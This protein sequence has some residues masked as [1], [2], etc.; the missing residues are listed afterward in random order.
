MTTAELLLPALQLV[1]CARRRP[2][3]TVKHASLLAL[4]FLT[5]CSLD[6][7]TLH[8]QY[9][10][11]MHAVHAA[12]EESLAAAAGAQRQAAAAATAPADR[13]RHERL[14]AALDLFGSEVGL[15]RSAALLQDL[16]RLS[17]AGSD[18]D[19]QQQQQASGGSQA[20]AAA[21]QH[22]AAYAAY[23]ASLARLCAAADGLEEEEQVRCL[24]ACKGGGGLACKGGS[25]QAGRQAAGCTHARR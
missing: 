17:A 16:Q 21:S 10:S 25:R 1:A 4:A 22:A 24:R 7:P 5:V 15:A 14:L 18:S 20:P 23:I 19:Q 11:D 12:L 8:T 13:Q 6:P 9:L 2:P 3:L